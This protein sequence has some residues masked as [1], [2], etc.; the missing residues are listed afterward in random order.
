MDTIV[1]W[2]R[3]FMGLSNFATRMIMKWH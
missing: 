2:N 3:S 1:T